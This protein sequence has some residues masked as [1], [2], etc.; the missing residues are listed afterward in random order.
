MRED[1]EITTRYF[2]DKDKELEHNRWNFQKNS[3]VNRVG[4]NLS[5]N[6]KGGGD[7]N[8]VGPTDEQIPFGKK[9][10]ELGRNMEDCPY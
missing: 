8:L 6:L 4:T 2:K 5:L 3:F 1:E 7:S 10:V 9:R